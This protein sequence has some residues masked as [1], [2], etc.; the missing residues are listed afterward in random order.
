MEHSSSIIS[1]EVLTSLPTGSACTTAWKAAVNRT[2]SSI[3]YISNALQNY[4]VRNKVTN[5]KII[6]GSNSSEL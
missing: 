3:P 4:Q 1:T 5:R 2:K 6:H